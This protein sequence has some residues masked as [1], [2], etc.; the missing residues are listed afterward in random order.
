MSVRFWT[1]ELEGL[2]L[3]TQ[4]MMVI[5]RQSIPTPAKP[6]ELVCRIWQASGQ[7][8]RLPMKALPASFLF[9][10][11][12]LFLILAGHVHAER[13][14]FIGNSYTSVN[15]LP[16]I[17]QDIITSTGAAEPEMK[18]ITPGGRTLEQHLSDPKT[19]NLVDEGKWDIV[20]IQGQS[21]EAAMSE[22]FDNMRT[23][24]LKGAKGLGERI[25]TTSPHAKIV[26]YQTWARH[27]DY[28][29]APEADLSV[30]KNP[31]DMQSGNRKWYQ[32]AA[33]QIQGAVIAPV[34]DAWMV[35]Y[36]GPNPIR[37]HKKDNSHPEFNGSYLAALVL[38]GT[39]HPTASLNVPYQGTLS[40]TEAKSLQDLASKTT[41]QSRK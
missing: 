40:P 37:L 13:I 3:K 18:S 10:L 38:F 16:E 36:V 5:F 6:L 22:L 1:G 39:I 12:C 21:Q 30:G 11:A 41:R 31:A 29:N 23:S 14:L 35:N 34:G 15:K 4:G 9:R 2:F 25:K 7:N 28:W 17:Y 32:Q 20:V 27:D 8:N 19:L 26:F 33:G 24:F